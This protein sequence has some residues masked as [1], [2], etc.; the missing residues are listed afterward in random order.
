MTQSNLTLF[1]VLEQMGWPEAV[2]MGQFAN[3]A[4]WLVASRAKRIN[5][6]TGLRHQGYARVRSA[7]PH[8][9]WE[10]YGGSFIIYAMADMTPEDRQLAAQHLAA[11]HQHQRCPSPGELMMLCRRARQKGGRS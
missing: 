7:A 10:V 8:G 4:P 5:L 9:L 1:E 3:A 6:T 2:T 11:A